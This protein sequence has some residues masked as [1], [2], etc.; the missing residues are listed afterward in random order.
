MLALNWGGHSM[1]SQHWVKVQQVHLESQAFE[2]CSFIRWVR[3]GQRSESSWFQINL[4]DFNLVLWD[5]L[6]CPPQS[7]AG[8]SIS[9]MMSRTFMSLFDSILESKLWVPCRSHSLYIHIPN[10]TIVVQIFKGRT[11][12]LKHSDKKNHKLLVLVRGE[13]EKAKRVLRK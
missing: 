8:I 13:S 9:W 3:K 1:K 12:G 6:L 2:R 10:G 7:N 4:L 5:F 11:N